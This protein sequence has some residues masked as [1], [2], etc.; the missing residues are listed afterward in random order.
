LLNFDDT[1]KRDRQ[2]TTSDD[3]HI[4]KILEML[5]TVSYQPTLT[6]Y[7]QMA[8]QRVN[9]LSEYGKKLLLSY[10]NL[11]NTDET[12][13]FEPNE[14]KG[15]TEMYV[16]K[17][18]I[19]KFFAWKDSTNNEYAED[20]ECFNYIL[21]DEKI[22]DK[23]IEYAQNVR[24]AELIQKINALPEKIL[25]QLITF[26]K[27]GK[28]VVNRGAVIEITPKKKHQIRKLHNNVTVKFFAHDDIF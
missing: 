19:P 6:P 12:F 15:R 16:L 26:F 8:F 4:A 27:F 25:L 7:A 14:N 2:L 11:F 3:Q 9:Q 21:E 13:K 22:E 5:R 24:F 1:A 17:M 20:I 10:V 23:K 28:S 18:F